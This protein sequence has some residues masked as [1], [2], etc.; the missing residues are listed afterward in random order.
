MLL[1]T[2]KLQFFDSGWAQ[3]FGNDYVCVCV[4]CVKIATLTFKALNTGLPLYLANF[5]SIHLPVRSHRSASTLFFGT[6][7]VFRSE[8][9]IGIRQICF[10]SLS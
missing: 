3:T 9:T 7:A 10:V 2:T 4:V 5:I 1:I 6:N 8:S